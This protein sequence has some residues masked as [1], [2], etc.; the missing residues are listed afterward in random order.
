[1]RHYFFLSSYCSIFIFITNL[2]HHNCALLCQCISHGVHFAYSLRLQITKCLILSIPFLTHQE[3]FFVYKPV[4]VVVTNVLPSI[5]CY[6]FLSRSAFNLLLLIM[7]LRT[8]PYSLCSENFI[9]QI[10]LCTFKFV[11]PPPG[12]VV[13]PQH[14]MTVMTPPSPS[15]W[16]K[17][18]ICLGLS[19]F[20]F[21]FISIILFY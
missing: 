6:Y 19:M 9:F 4:E 14:D 17:Q 16:P 2:L 5:F 18:C 1:M 21:S 8:S 15:Q 7:F 11:P 3:S 12:N 13:G 20:A 10:H